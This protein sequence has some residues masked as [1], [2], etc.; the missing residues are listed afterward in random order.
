VRHEANNLPLYPGLGNYIGLSLTGYGG[1]RNIFAAYTEALFPVTKKLELNAAIRYDHYSDAGNAV[2]PKVGAKFK[3]M[4]NLAF[5]GTYAYGFRAPSSTENSANSIAAFGGAVVDDNA[6][7]AAGVAASDCLGVAPTFVQRGNPSLEPEKS[8]SLTLGTVWDIT[9]KT[10]L[11]LDAWQIKRTGLPVI[12]DPQEAVNAGR[13]VVTR[14]PASSRAT[15]V[16]S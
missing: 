16:R 11:T 14:L 8:R 12:E 10:S 13:Y 4:D 3:A 5:R 7:C 2:T 15:R 1:D 6:R 9:A